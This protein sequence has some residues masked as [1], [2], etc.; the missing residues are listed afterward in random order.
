MV[1]LPNMLR[2]WDADDTEQDF[3]ATCRVVVVVSFLS[4]GSISHRIHV[5]YIYIYANIAGIGGILMVN[6]TI[7][8][9]L[10]TSLWL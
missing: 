4:V 6:V 7:Y 8:I 9:N 10:P 5:W 3:K 1:P 2:M